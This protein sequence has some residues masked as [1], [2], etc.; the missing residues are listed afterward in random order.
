MKK[1]KSEKNCNFLVENVAEKFKVEFL[2]PEKFWRSF[3]LEKIT[4]LR[5]DI[6]EHPVIKKYS[7]SW[8]FEASLSLSR[9]IDIIYHPDSNHH[10]V[11]TS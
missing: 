3:L 5:F 7:L 10:P 1:E 6:L 8:V 9:I 4:Y 11:G 2:L